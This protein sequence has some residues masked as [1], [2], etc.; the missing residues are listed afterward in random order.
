MNSSIQFTSDNTGWV[1]AAILTQL[2]CRFVY[3]YSLDGNKI[4]LT[5]TGS[6][7]GGSSSDK[8]FYYNE[9]GD[10][11]YTLINSQKYIFK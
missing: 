4:L 9:T 11:I 7:C 3:S 6:D 10:Y 5:Y 8:T 2:G 1:G